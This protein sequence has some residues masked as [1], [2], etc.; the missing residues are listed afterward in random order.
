[1]KQSPYRGWM[2]ALLAA[3]LIAVAALLMLPADTADAPAPA[4]QPA[5]RDETRQ[6]AEGCELLQTLTYT[7]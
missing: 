3:G 1:M 5:A 6:A 4:D 7:R 2:H